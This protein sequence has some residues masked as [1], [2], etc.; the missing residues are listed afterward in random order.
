MSKLAFVLVHGAWHDP[1]CWD[2]VK[3]ALSDQGFHCVCPALPS[4]HEP[5]IPDLQPDVDVVRSQVEK[6]IDQGLQVIVV[7]HSYGGI[8]TG[9]ALRDLDLNTR[10]LR[11]LPGG[12]VRLVYIMGFLVPEG[13]Q[14]SPRGSDEGLRPF[15]PLIEVDIKVC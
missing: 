3:H 8:P 15:K 14:Q 1:S 4:T 13:F 12:V 11:G 9:E 7:C 2:K 5:P 6:L 10:K